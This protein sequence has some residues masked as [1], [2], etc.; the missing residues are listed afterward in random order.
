MTTRVLIVDDEPIVTGAVGILA[1]MAAI[2]HFCSLHRF[3]LPRAPHRRQLFAN[4]PMAAGEPP[5]GLRGIL[6]FFT[7]STQSAW[8]CRASPAGGTR[9]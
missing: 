3:S 8:F 2:I 6:G 1:L 5:A 7:S 9:T 4:H